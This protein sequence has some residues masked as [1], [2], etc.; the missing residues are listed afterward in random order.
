MIDREDILFKE[1]LERAL[2]QV[3]RGDGKVP[4]F[5]Q[6]LRTVSNWEGYQRTLGR[7][8]GLEIAINKMN[9]EIQRLNGGEQVRS[10]YDRSMN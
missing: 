4:G 5:Y 2:M 3:L 9:E 10:Q 7:I 1:A 8:E 6:A